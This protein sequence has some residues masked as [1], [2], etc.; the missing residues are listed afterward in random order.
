MGSARAPLPRRWQAQLGEQQQQAAA[1]HARVAQLEQALK[2]AGAEAPPPA[3]PVPVPAAPA[4][5]AVG[6]TAASGLLALSIEPAVAGTDLPLL[7][8]IRPV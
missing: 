8:A 4:P 5:A 2:A 6:G 3:T 7:L 1:L